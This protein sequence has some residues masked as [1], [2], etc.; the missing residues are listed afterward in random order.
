MLTQFADEISFFIQKCELGYIL[1]AHNKN[2][3]CAI[4]I[5]DNPITLS[6]ALNKQYPT[7]KLIL[8]P[9]KNHIMNTG[10]NTIIDYIET[11]RTNLDLPLD[12]QGTPFQKQ[13]W[14][15]LQMIPKGNTAS[16]TDIA[17]FINYPKAVRAVANACAANNLAIVIPCHRIIRK[18]GELSSY[19]WGIEKKRLLLEKEAKFINPNTLN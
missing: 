10:L 7:S 4:F 1:L 8:L 19:R 15:A 14:K 2:G 6:D 12:I 18:N 11:S 17:N 5:N 9:E 16:Y 3:I 13:V